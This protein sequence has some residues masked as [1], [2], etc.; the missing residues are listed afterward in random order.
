MTD[1]CP[2][3]DFGNHIYENGICAMCC[4]PMKPWKSTTQPLKLTLTMRVGDSFITGKSDDRSHEVARLLRDVASMID[5]HPHFSA[6][7]SQPI[8]DRNGDECGY[9]E[10]DDATK[11]G[12][13]GERNCQQTG[14]IRKAQR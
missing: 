1:L 11:E 9:F 6:G 2:S 8:W 13:N 3:R 14:G 12:S 7:H 10:V 4:A 5:G